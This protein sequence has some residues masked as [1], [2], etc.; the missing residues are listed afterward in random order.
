MILLFSLS[1]LFRVHV[2]IIVNQFLGRV[3][4]RE[5]QLVAVAAKVVRVDGP[6]H[7]AAQVAL[8]SKE[9]LRER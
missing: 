1:F 9:C 3:D 5:W 2:L 8:E 7:D 4:Q 6:E